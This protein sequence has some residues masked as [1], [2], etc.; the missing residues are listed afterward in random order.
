MEFS[1]ALLGG[2]T[3]LFS[4]NALTAIVVNIKRG[5]MP[6]FTEYAIALLAPSTLATLFI[7]SLL[8]Y[9]SLC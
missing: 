4:I 6:N 1:I 5:D 8:K 7:F 3:L 2:L 9:I